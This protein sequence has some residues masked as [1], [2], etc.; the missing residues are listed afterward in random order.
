MSSIKY[1]SKEQSL[2]RMKQWALVA[3]FGAAILFLS[4]HIFKVTWLKAIGEAALVGGLAD[5]FAVVALFRHPLGLPIPHTALIPK[6]KNNIGKNLGMFVSEEFLTKEKLEHEID[7]HDIVNKVAKWLSDTKN[8][9]KI[10]NL[11]IDDVIPGILKVVN[12]E[13]V[14]RFIHTQFD[15]KIKSINFGELLGKGLDVLT[16]D[17]RH[18][19]L[20]T[21]I[22][23]KIHKEFYS[24]HGYIHNEVSEETPWYTFGLADKKIANGIIDGIDNFMHNAKQPNSD[25]RKKID[26][27]IMEFIEKAKTSVEMQKTINNLIEKLANNKNFQEYID[28]IWSEIKQCVISDLSMGDESKIQNSLVSMLQKLGEGLAEDTTL[29]NKIND[30]IKATVLTKLLDN[31][32]AIGNFIASTVEKWDSK[33][34]SEKLE[35]EIGKDLQFIRLNGTLVGGVIGLLLF[36]LLQA[37]G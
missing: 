23:E 34:V 12:D 16:K 32:Q 9:R 19:E 31:R 3:L 8:F 27:Y 2:N 28:G 33:E 11:I 17:G 37:V 18:Q 6:N 13:D 15:A 14:K 10:S 4:G 21:D 26:T 20:F 5:W 22:L 30:F 24:Y 29:K 35:L 25:V 7:K 1:A 36:L